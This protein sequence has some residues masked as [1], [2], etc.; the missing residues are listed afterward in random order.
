MN[1][2]HLESPTELHLFAGAGGGILAGQLLGHQC[3]CA[4]EN[5]PYA[6]AVLVARQNDGT[7]PP[8]PIYGDVRYFDGRPWRGI[9][10]IV[11]GGFPCQDISAAGTGAGIEG[12]RSGLWR[13]MARIIREVRPRYAFMENSPI[14]TSRGLE[15]VLGDLASMGLDA[16]W[17]VLGADDLGAPHRRKRIWIL[18]HANGARELQSE[19]L[20]RHKRGWIGYGCD[21]SDV[22]HAN[23]LCWRH[24]TSGK[25]RKKI[26]NDR[27][28]ISDTNIDELQG[29]ES[30]PQQGEL[31]RPIGLHNR[32]RIF[33]AWPDDP[34]D[35]IKPGLGR[36]VDRLANRANRI[37][38]IGNGQVPRVAAAAFS[39]LRNRLLN[40]GQK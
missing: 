5:D 15:T 23:G 26:G 24:G 37:R 6:Q 36:V 27:A 29:M 10:D 2:H 34:A 9:V 28:P 35:E 3:I 18:A 22:A 20:E 16:E 39:L 19:R 31:E 25:N 17:C 40:I 21:E 4:V 30:E 32:A 7:F 11:A 14:L 38:A 12:E 8:F 13:E 1:G 33:P